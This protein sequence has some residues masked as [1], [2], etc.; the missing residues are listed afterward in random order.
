MLATGLAACDRVRASAPAASG[1]PAW[2]ADSTLIAAKPSV[3]FRVLRDSAGT[4]VV[5]VAT[6][7]GGVHSLFLSD[8][9]WRAFDLA[10]FHEQPTV[11]PFRFGTPMARVTITR[12]MWE[13][14]ALDTLDGCA[15]VVPAAV[16]SVPD[17]VELVTSGAPQPLRTMPPLGEE[18]LRVALEA[19]DK[20]V[21]PTAGIP[22]GDLS[23]Y[24]RT[25]HVA[26][27]G[28]GGDPTI[29]VSYDDPKQP[30]DSVL[31][32]GQRPM[33]LIV[34]LDKGVYGYKPSYTFSDIS[35][36]RIEMRRRYLGHLDSDGDGKAELYFGLQSG[37]YPLV[38]F[39]LRHAVDSWNES[40]RYDRGR[41]HALSR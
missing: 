6:V 3:L 12:G 23:R 13:G 5:P 28:I 36:A 27:A 17:A 34:V 14:S 35:N 2:Q 22:L 32:V 7:G 39:A 21:A 40:W 4:K 20:L 37:R 9:G 10:Y 18:A 19:T 41:C 30:P 26:A 38:T 31:K 16:A 24:T 8:R 15:I 25:V 29:I 1:D 33:Q 11:V